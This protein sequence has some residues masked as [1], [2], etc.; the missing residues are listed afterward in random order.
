MKARKARGD[1]QEID[2]ETG[3][4]VYQT[5]DMAR[6]AQDMTSDYGVPGQSEIDPDTEYDKQEDT[7]AGREETV[8]AQVAA[9]GIEF[10]DSIRPGGDTDPTVT[11]STTV[12]DILSGEP[13]G[14]EG[15]FGD[16]GD[17]ESK[18]KRR[19]RVA[20]GGKLTGRKVNKLWRDG[21]F[22]KY[23]GGA[24]G[25]DSHKRWT[26]T[27]RALSKGQDPGQ[28]ALASALT[29][30][31]KGVD[32]KTGRLDRTQQLALKSATGV[33]PSQALASSAPEAAPGPAGVPAGVAAKIK[34][35]TKTLGELSSNEV[36]SDPKI[37]K[38]YLDMAKRLIAQ[39]ISAA[40]AEESAR[41]TMGSLLR[42]RIDKLKLSPSKEKMLAKRARRAAKSRL[43]AKQFGGDA[44][45]QTATPTLPPM[46]E[47]QLLAVIK[48]ELQ[49]VMAE[50]Y[51]D[52][53]GDAFGDLDKKL[54]KQK[55]EPKPAAKKPAAK[56]AVPKKAAAKK[57]APAAPKKVGKAVTLERELAILQGRLKKSLGKTTGNQN[58]R[59]DQIAMLKRRIEAVQKKIEDR[60]RRTAGG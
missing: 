56:K 39:G 15:A 59:K 44:T 40:D 60:D 35:D 11:S 28:V 6:P 31:G 53:A 46:R 22:G 57:A 51:R 24:K 21:A 25:T 26:R 19:P 50:N 42:N 14:V 32:P 27:R 17:T 49:A 43:A 16:A 13:E 23:E 9:G 3:K 41:G 5:T 8:G 48:E 34:Q 55:V 36:P 58:L 29:K 10:D 33:T 30:G 47:G 7:L 4:I 12:D 2:P 18:P 52:R 37:R 38:R 45:T 54:S 20:S 1:R